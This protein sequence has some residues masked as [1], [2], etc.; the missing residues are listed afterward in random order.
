MLPSALA[1]TDT[2]RLGEALQQARGARGLT[3]EDAARH[4][5]VARTT[6]TAIE[7]GDRKVKPAEL[8]ALATLYGRS[9]NDL[10]G[11]P[12][13]D[14]S[15]QPQFRGE[16]RREALAE[17]SDLAGVLDEFAQLCRDYRWLE[18][19]VDARP[20]RHDPPSYSY[21]G[22]SPEQ[23]G[24]DVAATERMRMGLGDGPIE[25]LRC[26]LELDVG[27]RIFQ[28]QLPSRVSAI[29]AYTDDLGGC[30]MLNY[31]H[32]S[33]R[34]NWS[35]AH[36]YGH[37]LGDRFR[38]SVDLF[39]P[40]ERKP[41]AERFA[42][43][44]AMH[45]LMP[46]SGIRRRSRDIVQACGDFRAA[47]LCQLAHVYSV[48]V[49]AMCLRLEQL[50]LIRAG[51]WERLRDSGFRVRQAQRAL[52]LPPEETGE[53]RLPMRY[54]SLGI[55][56]FDE[57]KLSEGQLTKVLRMPRVLAR[58]TAEQF[59]STPETDGAGVTGSLVVDDI[60][61]SLTSPGG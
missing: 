28:W 1:E 13:V 49:Q 8:V 6:V 56:A 22:G 40:C 26:I 44:F 11:K 25:N 29:Y 24:E 20:I 47:D 21:R 43:A 36:E 41:D 23:A 17:D 16:L 19:L 5:G 2:R 45:F 42:D 39:G 18:E 55:R 35:L 12:P 30:V 50:K 52:G 4:L 10:L 3:Q 33:R 57:E 48:S 9:V 7:K 15:F 53:Q 27:M 58:L 51:A 32:P 31:G 34:K 38:A 54:I 59:R 37:F 60:S 46:T 61:A 14:Q